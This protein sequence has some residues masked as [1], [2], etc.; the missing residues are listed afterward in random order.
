MK[1]D[2]PLFPPLGALEVRALRIPVG[3]FLLEADFRI[4]P[5][6][7][8]AL[9]G[10][11]GAG[12]TTLL[13]TLVGLDALGA[14]SG[15][16]KILLGG[17][18]LTRMAPE[19]RGFGYVAQ[20]AS[21][22]P[23]W[24]ALEN[25]IYGLKVRGM[26]ASMARERTLPLLEAAG[27][28]SLA[29]RNPQEFSGGERQRLAVVRALAFSPAALLFDEPFASLDARSREETAALIARL[30][31]ERPVPLLFTTHADGDV[32]LLDA[33]EWKIEDD[34]DGTRHVRTPPSFNSPLSFPLPAR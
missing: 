11:S 33:V 20:E 27:L 28:G 7:R 3:D 26:K 9:R 14:R 15:G 31:S 23:E 13:R 22:F 21:F 17:R 34:G 10:R 18:D 30:C 5:G 12:K 4:A 19:R 32:A 6:Q 16:G 2:A 8:V 24:D 1:Q 25:A 29:L